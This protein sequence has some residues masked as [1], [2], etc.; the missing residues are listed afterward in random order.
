MNATVLGYGHMADGNIH[1]NCPGIEENM[2]TTVKEHLE[3][4]VYEWVVKHGGSISAEHGIGMS[5]KR[6]LAIQKQPLAIDAMRCIKDI[7]D[8]KGIMNPGKIIDINEP[9]GGASGL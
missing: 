5:K 2:I 3:P 8:P 7:F 6:F 1:V 9:S 4:F